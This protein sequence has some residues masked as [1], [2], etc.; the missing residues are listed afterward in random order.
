MA[1]H[2]ADPRICFWA[3]LG[4]FCRHAKG[5]L[6][7][8]VKEAIRQGFTVYGLSEHIPRYRTEDLYPEEVR[9][10]SFIT[11]KLAIA[12]SPNTTGGLIS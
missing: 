7:A 8:V 2:R 4:Q 3:P 12:E 11:L 6:E 5:Q 1:R 9:Q 10:Q